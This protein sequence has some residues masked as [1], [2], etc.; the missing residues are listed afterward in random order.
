MTTP[1]VGLV[2]QL[3]QRTGQIKD[4]LGL[5]TDPL[6]APFLCTELATNQDSDT[7][8]CFK[9]GLPVSKHDLILGVW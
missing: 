1:R 9:N 5:L 4:P 8:Y 2:P 6:F 3:F 7:N